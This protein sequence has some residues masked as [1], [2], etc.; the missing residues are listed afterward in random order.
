MKVR[1][2]FV[3][4]SSSSSFIVSHDNTLTLPQFIRNV[5]KVSNWPYRKV[6]TEKYIKNRTCLNILDITVDIDNP[7]IP[8]ETFDGWIPANI[9]VS[10]RYIRRFFDKHGEIKEN[11]DA[12]KIIL[13][14]MSYIHNERKHT[15]D[16]NHNVMEKWR[17]SGKVNEYSVK[18]TN[19]LIRNIKELYGYVF[20]EKDCKHDVDF[21]E[22]HL[23]QGHSCYV[24]HFNYQGTSP[25]EFKGSIRYNG[26][27]G[28]DIA[29]K[30]LEGVHGIRQVI[31]EEVE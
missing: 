6:K 2:D 21:V 10:D 9:C 8:G 24:L 15:W 23:K 3:S 25:T 29:V 19:W 16:Y 26:N 1:A 22:E 14:L 28:D 31:N 18:F 17:T 20:L 11:L 7:D 27:R 12:K 5:C 13:S 30:L 4:N